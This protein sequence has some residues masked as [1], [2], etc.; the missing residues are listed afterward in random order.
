[1]I[2]PMSVLATLCLALGLFPNP[3]FSLAFKSAQSLLSSSNNLSETREAVLANLDLIAFSGTLLL[4]MGLSLWAFRRILF[5]SKKIGQGPVWAC[6]FESPTPRMQYTGSSY[7]MPLQRILS[8]VLPMREKS[9]P[10]VG[11]WPQESSFETRT[12]EPALE[13]TIPLLTRAFSERLSKTRKIHHGKIQ[14]YL[15]YMSAF[16][17]FLLLWKL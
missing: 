17:I 2:F 9:R 11:Y 14:Y 8:L 4:L 16:L 13:I 10:P 5:H 7:A 3:I 12:P 15:L 1:M 6:G